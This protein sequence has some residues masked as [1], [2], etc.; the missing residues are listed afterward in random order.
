MRFWAQQRDVNENGGWRQR[1]WTSTFLAGKELEL[2]LEQPI[3]SLHHPKRKLRLSL[4]FSDIYTQKH[5][6]LLFQKEIHTFKNYMYLAARHKELPS[7]V[8]LISFLIPEFLPSWK[9]RF[10]FVKENHVSSTGAE[11]YLLPAIVDACF[12]PSS[13]RSNPPPTY[14]MLP[15]LIIQH[16]SERDQSGCLERLCFCPHPENSTIDTIDG[17]ICGREVL[18][19]SVDQ[20]SCRSR[21]MGSPAVI[22][23]VGS[24]A[25]CCVRSEYWFALLYQISLTVTRNLTL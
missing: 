11:G 21:R 8:L 4:K 16:R 17:Q 20:G 23:V 2:K 6:H 3:S 14:P 24:R 22:G 12:R 19:H 9:L 10:D 7:T 13:T 5:H 25:A 1:R 15:C 18:G